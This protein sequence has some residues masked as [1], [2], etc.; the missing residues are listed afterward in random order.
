MKKVAMMQPTFLPWI[1]YF[2]L[3]LEA[4]TFVFLDDFQFVHRSFDQRNRLFVSKDR[5][6]WI[7][8][9]VDK[10]CGFRKPYT[11][12][13]IL[14]T[15]PWRHKLWRQMEINYGKSLYFSS[16]GAKLQPLLLGNYKFIAEQNISLIMKI[17]ELLEINC[18]IA[19]SSQLSSYGKRSTRIKSLLEEIGA[20]VYLSA[21]GSFEYM[22]E[23]A[24][25]H[26]LREIIS[27]LVNLYDILNICLKMEC[28]HWIIFLFYFRMQL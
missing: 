13:P 6:D 22:L 19:Y 20:S 27:L 15:T 10:K 2:E 8:V 24:E 5:V 9:P 7:T 4:D 11:E 3:M 14:E 23:D 25:C 28:F 1:G 12:V 26:G 16:I 21:R 18:E 17:C